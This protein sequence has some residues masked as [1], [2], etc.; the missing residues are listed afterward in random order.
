MPPVYKRVCKLCHEP[1]K[2]Y[3]NVEEFDAHRSDRRGKLCEECTKW[4]LSQIMGGDAKPYLY[5][6]RGTFERLE[7]MKKPKR[8]SEGEK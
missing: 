7:E 5:V 4:L 8:K 3:V 6:P 2:A 1:M